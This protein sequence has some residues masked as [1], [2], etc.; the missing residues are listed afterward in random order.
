MLYDWKYGPPE[1]AHSPIAMHHFGS[2]ICSQRRTS[3]SANF[4]L[5]GPF[6]NKTSHWRGLDLKKTPNRSASNRLAP[7]AAI[8]SAQHFIPRWR[9]KSDF[10]WPQLKSLP[11]KTPITSL[12]LDAFRAS[13]V[14][15]PTVSTRIL[16]LKTA[17]FWLSSAIG[18]P[19]M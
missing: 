2:G 14:T 8:S 1:I 12:I 11:A 17:K 15:W 10:L 9:G 3:G 19:Q 5:T 18:S 7:A 13:S 6:T 4:L 16:L